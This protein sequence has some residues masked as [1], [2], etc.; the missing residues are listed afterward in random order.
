M[1]TIEL[2]VEGMDCAE[3]AR[4][5]A[6]ALEQ[7]PGVCRVEVLL[8]AQKAVLEVDPARPPEPDALR[9]AVEAAGY[10]VPRTETP[11]PAAPPARRTAGLL[12]FL[13]GAVL[14]VVVLGEWLGLFEQLTARVPLPIGIALVV[15]LGY[16][17]FRQ[18]VQALLRGRILTHTLMSIGALAALAVGAWPTAA[19][20]V[21][22]MRV[23]DYV[24]R[25]TTEQARSALRGLSRLMPRTARVERGGELVELPAEAVQPGDVVLVRPGE[26]VPVD[27][28]VLEGTATLDTSALTGESMPAEVGPGDAVLAASLVRQGYLRLKATRTGAATTF[29][30]ILHL[31]ETAEANRSATERLA[32][33]FSAYYLPVV[34]AVAL[35]TYLLR[36][37]VMATVAVL[38]VA[39]S[40]AF[41]LATPVA[42]LAA[43]GAA[44][45]QGIVIKG[46]RYLEALARADVVLLDKTGTLTLGRPRLTDLVPLD[47]RSPDALLALAAAAEYA[48]EHPLAEAIREAARARGLP[49]RRPDEARPLPGVGIEARLDG[50]RVRLQ[51]LPE[52]DA[53]PEAARLAAEGKTLI[54]MEVDGRPAALLAAADTERPGLREALEALRALGVH[55]LELLTGDHPR[56]AEPLARRL[57]LRCRAGLLPDDKIRI[58]R[59]YQARGHTVVMIGDGVNDAPALLQADVG[60]AMGSGTDVALDTAAIVLLRDDWRQLPALFR[61]ARR[62]RRT[63]A[64]NLGFTA[65][66]NLVGLTLAA[67]GY[68]PPVLAAAAQ[69]LPDLGIL[70]N[71]ARLLRARLSA[72]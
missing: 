4:H 58:V 50:H 72:S 56:A 44:A 33:R 71:S 1:K 59:E 41:A 48:S 63:I 18:V 29:G 52:P 61:L 16:P 9:R 57:G 46:G 17:V 26:R 34:A 60:I 51:R 40:C 68:L 39:C 45:R 20:V 12:A 21:F 70:G 36:G 47:G 30:R 14:T 38:V 24:E 8:A 11:A 66:Y 64:V 49:L 10:R 19:V 54:L 65:L 22:F 28:E 69:S 13:F 7:V 25:F 27:G 23:G 37:D 43:V 32:D 5:V 31:V 35:G 42:V 67:L 55:H 15:V 62:T 53:F 2:P 6:R 3:C